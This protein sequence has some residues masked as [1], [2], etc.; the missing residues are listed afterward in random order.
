MH[1]WLIGL[2]STLRTKHNQICVTDFSLT[3][4]DPNNL[5]FVKPEQCHFELMALQHTFNFET[6]SN[7]SV[8]S[9]CVWQIFGIFWCKDHHTPASMNLSVE[10][11]LPDQ[12]PASLQKHNHN[13]TTAHLIHC[14]CL[15]MFSTAVQNIIST[16]SLLK[17][18]KGL[19]SQKKNYEMA[20]AFFFTLQML[21]VD[22]FELTVPN[23]WSK[24]N[25]GSPF[26]K[27]WVS[28]SLARAGLHS[29]V[30][31]QLSSNA[32][33]HSKYVDQSTLRC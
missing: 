7:L 24:D 6:F 4:S 27:N 20:K 32:S 15:P 12:R 1:I 25:S 18:W 28:R 33:T 16:I 29:F 10:A 14:D 21:W 9:F 8:N 23:R 11:E 19:A 17:T 31:E 30:V 22:I 26:R 13:V 3:F 2:K 5:H